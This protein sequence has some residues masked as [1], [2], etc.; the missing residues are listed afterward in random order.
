MASHVSGSPYALS[1][2]PLM[3][4]HTYIYLCF[5]KSKL[6]AYMASPAL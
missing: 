6:E 2:L 4:M 1:T 5:T 3:V